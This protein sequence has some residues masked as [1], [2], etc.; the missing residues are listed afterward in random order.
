MYEALF[1]IPLLVLFLLLIYHSLKT[2]G[3]RTAILFFGIALLFAFFREL[4]IGLTFP[5]YAGKFKIG[6]ISPAIVLG[7]VFAFY[8]GN[9]FVQTLLTNTKFEKNLFVK[10]SL[11]TYVVLGISFVM[12]T[13]APLLEW[14]SWKPGLLESLP[15]EAIVFGA[16]IFVFVGWGITGA[17]F[18]AIYY[19]LE[20]YNYELKA[21]LIDAVIYFMI[22]SN[23]I[24]CNYIIL[25]GLPF[26]FP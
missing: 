1:I 8:L 11:G 25:Y 24:I 21:I 20:Y 15:P 16:P 23:F 4:I 2:E 5:L 13:T 19:I 3:K 9:Y 18:F 14:W 26:P 6:P 7:W 10:I 22:M 12:E 17:A